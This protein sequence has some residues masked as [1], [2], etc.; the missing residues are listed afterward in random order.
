MIRSFLRLQEA[1]SGFVEEALLTLRFYVA[2]DAYDRL[3]ARAELLRTLEERLAAL[4]G[5]RK[6]AASP[7]ASPP[8][9]AAPRCGS[10]SS[11]RPVPPGR[12]PRAIRIVGVALAL[13]D[14]GSAP[15]R[16]AHLHGGRARLARGRRGRSSTRR[17]ARRFFPEGA[18]GRGWRS[19]TAADGRGRES[20]GCASSASHPTSSTRSSARRRRSRASTCS[21]RTPP[22]PP[23]RWRSSCAPTTPRAQAE[24]VR[25]VFR[26]LDPGL[27][28]WDVRTMEEVRAFTTWEQRFFGQLMGAFAAQALLLAC[29]GV[30]GVLAYAVSRRTH[31]IGVRLALG[32]A[33]RGRGAPGAAARRGAR[34]ARD[35]ARAAAVPGGGP[36]AAGNPLRRRARG[37]APAPRHRGSCSWPS[38]SRRACCRRCA[39][40]RSIRSP[41]CAPSRA[42]EARSQP[43]PPSS[44]GPVAE[45]DLHGALGARRQ[46][47]AAAVTA[48]GAGHPGDRHRE[49]R[50][51][52]DT[53]VEV[54]HL[55]T[56]TARRAAMRIA[57]PGT[58]LW[59]GGLP[60]CRQST[61][62][63]RRSG[64]RQLMRSSG[65]CELGAS[66]TSRGGASRVASQ[67]ATS[68]SAGPVFEGVTTVP[69]RLPSATCFWPPPG[70][71]SQPRN[72]TSPHSRQLLAQRLA[73]ADRHR[74]VLAGHHVRPE[75]LRRLEAQPRR[76][77]LLAARHGP[78]AVDA[79]DLEARAQGL[80]QAVQAAAGRRRLRRPL[81]AQHA[82][83]GRDEGASLAALDPPDLPL[84]G[85]ERRD[86]ELGVRRAEL[87]QVRD[88]RVHENP[89][90]AGLDGVAG[91]TLEALAGGRLH[92]DRDRPLRRAA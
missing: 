38:C 92:D 42:A 79:A 85:A 22:S 5:D 81:H 51:L 26:E 17:L 88:L 2:G 73:R 63:K 4:P 61:P 35:G 71:P 74:V 65:G 62:A 48:R 28:I 84:V 25:R 56:D 58:R 78:V 50:T 37:A 34:P 13:R 8:T 80:L 76:D 33:A 1:P 57:L 20:A 64:C 83:A 3:E 43:P 12:S 29:L 9:T 54:G 72:G 21:G 69:A 40:R 24:A 32:R 30:Y 18:L 91:D 46:R 10:R 7:P 77:R 90:D 19:W 6:A 49:Q 60:R 47:D 23:A 41:R 45:L 27:A 52:P 15:R 14:P 11:G 53:V 68:S 67:R 86:R 39:P 89:A 31:E 55:E 36:R 82:T 59:H 87:V 70:K 44:A 16:G 75:G 66:S